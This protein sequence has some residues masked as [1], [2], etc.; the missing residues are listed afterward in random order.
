MRKRNVLIIMSLSIALWSVSCR[1][2]KK[3]CRERLA[4]EY[5]QEV[6]DYN[7]MVES[8]KEHFDW[9]PV[10]GGLIEVKDPPDITPALYGLVGLG[11]LQY[12]DE[13]IPRMRKKDVAAYLLQKTA[14]IEGIV[15]WQNGYIDPGLKADGQ[16]AEEDDWEIWYLQV[17][18]R[19]ESLSAVEDL[20]V[21]LK[22]RGQILSSANARN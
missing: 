2:S 18:Y 7:E 5:W 8:P 22:E 9:E 13:V 16:T 6:R 19:K 15:Y 11:K 4:E 12:R 20:V 14:E 17:W 21:E 1:S 3:D 10:A